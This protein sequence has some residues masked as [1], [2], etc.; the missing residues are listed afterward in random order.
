MVNMYLWAYA[1]IAVILSLFGIRKYKTIL[2]VLT[3]KLIIFSISV[4]IAIPYYVLFQS[5][6]PEE[7]KDLAAMLS[8]I[9]IIS[10]AIPFF[11]N[12]NY[13]LRVYERFLACIK[14][15]YEC[16]LKSYKTTVFL[17]VL[18]IASI[19][20]ILLMFKS[21]AGMLWITNPRDAY[22]DYRQGVGH[23]YA[24]TM[25]SLMLSYIYFLWTRRPK[26]GGVILTLSFSFLAY[27]LGSKGFIICFWIVFALYWEYMVKRIKKMNVIII[28]IIIFSLFLAVQF[29]QGTAREL[30]DGI[31]YFVYFEATSRFLSLIDE[32]G[33]QYG[34]AFI[35]QFWEIVPRALVPN[36]PVVYGHYIIHETLNPGL[37]ETGRAVGVLEWTKFYL[38][39]GIFGVFFGGLSYGVIIKTIYAHFLKNRK[40]IVSFMIMLQFGVI[41]IFNYANSLIILILLVMFSLLLRMC[42]AYNYKLK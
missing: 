34:G 39:F 42:G 11:I 20:Y 30:S 12:T 36:K 28:G 10:I 41:S 24:L 27:F 23:F 32:V 38:D 29:L 22:M 37:L 40:N 31:K 14:F 15:D 21:E 33:Y 9:Y 5:D 1:S 4:V 26:K 18:I 6:A 3:I 13:I 25:W 16:N 8:I 7:A 35:G 19:S 2:N 17:S